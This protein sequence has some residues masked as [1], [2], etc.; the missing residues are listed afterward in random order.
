MS[1][2]VERTDAQW[3]EVLNPQEFQ[4]LRQAGTERAF[5]GALLNEERPGTYT[6]RAC[7]NELFNAT[8]KFDA[9]CG[10]PS[11]WEPLR[12]GAVE[13]LE[14]NTLGMRRVEV[15]CAKCG[16]HLGHVFPDGYGT[17]TGDRFCMNSVSLEFVPATA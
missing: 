17:P 14:D 2:E 1:Y 15:R 3:R 16:S 10:W 4:V 9:G 11:F 8:T 5:T 12:E 7:G 6:C 13:Y